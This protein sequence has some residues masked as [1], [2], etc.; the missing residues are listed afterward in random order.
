MLSVDNVVRKP[1][2][3]LVTW[4]MFDWTILL[5]ILANCA[6][7][8]MGSSRPGFEQT[9]MGMSLR[10]ANFVFVAIFM[11]EAACK[12]I[13]LGFAFGEYTYLRSGKATTF[14]RLMQ[15]IY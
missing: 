6:T 5:F 15:L 13:A 12:I 4:K 7:L 8:A 14:A 3:R 9:E 2:L 10:Y 1:L 11:F